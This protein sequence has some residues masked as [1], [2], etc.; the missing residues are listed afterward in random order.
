MSHDF[1]LE[2]TGRSHNGDQSRT[3]GRATKSFWL[4][5]LFRRFRRGKYREALATLEE[6][7]RETEEDDPK[8]AREM[9]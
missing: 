9:K 1:S 8:T 6:A 4:H 2:A 5:P 3:S 7:M